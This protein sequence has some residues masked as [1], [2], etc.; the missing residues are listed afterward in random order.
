MN[1]K[2]L[3]DYDIFLRGQLTVNVPV[4]LIII[5]IGFGLSIHFDVHFKIAMLIGVI[6]G[7]IY[8]GL[9]VKRWIQSAVQKNVDEERLVKIGRKGLFVWSEVL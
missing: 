2:K 1:D 7:W 3:S 4:V 6:L 9:S 8:W 5:I